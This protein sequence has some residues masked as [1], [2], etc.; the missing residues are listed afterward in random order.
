MR[1]E[2]LVAVDLGKGSMPWRVWPQQDEVVDRGTLIQFRYNR[3]EYSAYPGDTVASALVAAGVDRLSRSKAKQPRGVFCAAGHCGQCLVE[4]EGVRRLACRTRVETGLS[5]RSLTGGRSVVGQ[6]VGTKPRFD[7]EPLQTDLVVVGG[8]PAGLG[9]AL[10]AAKA[11]ARVVLIDENL[12]LGGHLRYTP[13]LG[14]VMGSPL[15]ELLQ[16]VKKSKKITVLIQAKVVEVKEGWQVRV[17]GPEKGWD[18]KTSGLVV[19]TGAYDRPL[20][21]EG[22]DKPG[23]FSAEGAL[24][25]LMEYGVVP[26]KRVVVACT[27]AAGITVAVALN[28]AGVEVAAVVV[29]GG[30]EG[31]TDV[32]ELKETGV[33]V[34]YW[35][36]VLKA[37]GVRVKSALIACIDHQ[38]RAAMGTARRVACEAIVVSAGRSP[39]L[40]LVRLS[41]GQVDFDAKVGAF[42][43]LDTPPGIW[44]A[45]RAGGLEDD[46]LAID[47]GRRAGRAAAAYLNFKGTVDEAG[48]VRLAASAAKINTASKRPWCI[49]G[50]EALICVCQD[51]QAGEVAAALAAG[52]RDAAMVR[53]QTAVTYGHCQGRMCAPYLA[54]LMDATIGQAEGDRPAPTFIAKPLQGMARLEG[55]SARQSPAYAWHKEHNAELVQYEGWWWPFSY[56]DVE[57]EIK[58]V[59][60]E[61]GLVDLS[62]L[63]KIRCSGSRLGEALAELAGAGWNTLNTGFAQFS[64][65]SDAS[66]RALVEATLV[67][68]DDTSWD[69]TCPPQQGGVLMDLLNTAGV[70]SEDLTQDYAAFMLAGPQARTV[71]ASLTE[72]AVD[73]TALPFMAFAQMPVA[74]IDCR[75]WCLEFSGALAL[76]LHCPWAEGARLWEALVASTR[77]QPVGQRALDVLRLEEGRFSLV[78]DAPARTYPLMEERV[79]EDTAGLVRVGAQGQR[80][81]LRPFKMTNLRPL[82]EPGR[83]IVRVLE[84]KKK[85]LI[86]WVS[87]CAYSPTLEATI[88]LCWLPEERAQT[89]MAFMVEMGGTL[90]EGR[91][92]A[93]RF[94]NPGS[95][96]MG[97]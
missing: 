28:K 70:D 89:G 17:L 97:S 85:E 74:S 14:G 51:V 78:T 26:G 56:G 86:G 15:D 76:E 43:V 31:Q 46:A 20:I 3:K 41:G 60:Q 18:I 58:A 50:N 45:G 21:F 79:Q 75:V 62:P 30:G 87:S 61:A 27:D 40:E 35:H 33:P 77:V 63:S 55:Q 11:G 13:V 22:H 1:P 95:E 91:V 5:V 80:L 10:S 96:A 37:G 72:D 67:R 4:V 39:A 12:A 81:Y 42:R 93:G 65:L 44:V 29:E 88:G 71:L 8:G 54:Q 6:G 47:D 38:G 83:Q 82:P 90:V 84:K 66:G 68:T 92:Y 94:Y 2:N 53:Q 7:F 57:T 64:V 24:R 52:C 69:I 23:V 73:N 9:A 36:A 16:A 48:E 34:F 59:R 25:L 32:A 49:K 19:A